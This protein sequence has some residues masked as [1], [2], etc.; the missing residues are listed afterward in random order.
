MSANDPKRCLAN[1]FF[2]G[3]LYKLATLEALSATALNSAPVQALEVVTSEIVPAAAAANKAA[4]ADFSLVSFRDK[5]EVGVASRE[6]EVYK[7]AAGSL[8]QL[9]HNRFSV[10]RCSNQSLGI[11]PG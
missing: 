3:G 2:P 1:Y 5:Q 9:P 4:I 11:I 7:S 8:D 6:V 10:L